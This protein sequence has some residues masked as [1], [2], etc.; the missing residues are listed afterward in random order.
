MFGDGARFEFPASELWEAIPARFREP[1]ENVTREVRQVMAELGREDEVYGLVHADLDVK[2]NVLFAGGEARV[3]DFDDCGFAYWLHDLAFALSPWQGSAEEPWVQDALLEGYAE[4]RSLPGSQLKH[5]DLFMAAF[6]ATLMLWM[7]D[8][9]KLCPKASEPW[10]YVDRYG[11]N[12]LR[13]YEH[14]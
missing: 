8:W 9:S 2:T 12:L 10:K 7:I 3:I 14:R 4:I 5:L 11:S 6:N 1:F 13:Y